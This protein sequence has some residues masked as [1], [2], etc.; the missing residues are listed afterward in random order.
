MDPATTNAVASERERQLKWESSLLFLVGVTKVD[1]ALAI[2]HQSVTPYGATNRQNNFPSGSRYLFD[3]SKY[4]GIGSLE[5]ITNNL[6]TCCHGCVLYP[7]RSNNGT[8]SAMYTLHCSHYFTQK[9]VKQFEPGRFTQ[10]GA[11]TESN[12]QRGRDPSFS[13]MSNPK[14]KEGKG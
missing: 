14:I 13:R 3:P 8:I 12:K 5:Q 9:G 1:L 10:K 11:T 6:Q 4:T 2:G 7:Q